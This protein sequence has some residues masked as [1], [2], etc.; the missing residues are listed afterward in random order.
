MTDLIE[1]WEDHVIEIQSTVGYE[2]QVIP[3]LKVKEL[4]QAQA[5]K[6]KNEVL[7]KIVLEEKQVNS[8]R[9]LMEGYGKDDLRDIKIYN[10]AVQDLV[11]LKKEVLDGRLL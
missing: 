3:R 1:G 2:W 11:E 7:D 9:L 5:T 6:T 8:R 4:L 10:Q